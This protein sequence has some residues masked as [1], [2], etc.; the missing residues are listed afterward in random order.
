M[1]AR[2]TVDLI[3]KPR[4]TIPVCKII[5]EYFFVIN[6]FLVLNIRL[7][8]IPPNTAKIGIL[9]KILTNKK[10]IK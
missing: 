7:K 6:S 5:V 4:R 3:E 9:K 8:I 10:M 2:I 1:Q